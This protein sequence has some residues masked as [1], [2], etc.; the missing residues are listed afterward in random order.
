MLMPSC[1]SCVVVS[2]AAN[3]FGPTAMS[4]FFTHIATSLRASAA[5][6]SA[7][8][9]SRESVA[10]YVHVAGLHH[11][12][13]V[14]HD[15]WM[16]EHASLHHSIIITYASYLL[17]ATVQHIHDP[18][19]TELLLL[20]LLTSHHGSHACAQAN[21][22]LVPGWSP[23]VPCIIRQDVICG[24]TI[25][26]MPACWPTSINQSINHRSPVFCRKSKDLLDFVSP[27]LPIL[28]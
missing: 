9:S 6:T 4:T 2:L 21:A 3:L 12:D 18:T 7:R 5:G 1:C 24:N 20:L 13:V 27:E 11:T 16:R 23:I 8:M 22:D 28:G 15:V 14:Q 10:C 17:L 25:P 26:W 19:A